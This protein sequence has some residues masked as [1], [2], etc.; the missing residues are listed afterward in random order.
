MPV[1]GIEGRAANSMADAK[2]FKIDGKRNNS[3]VYR[4]QCG[5]PNCAQPC[6]P[7]PSPPGKCVC[8]RA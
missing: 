1:K 8:R 3:I 6:K 5:V 4:G 7:P 2:E